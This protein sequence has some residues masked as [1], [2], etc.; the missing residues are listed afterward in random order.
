MIKDIRPALTAFLLA[1]AGI[2]AAVGTRVYPVRLPQGTA[3]ASVV[4]N[5][6]SAIG[7]HTMQGASGLARPRI[8]IDC[9][10]P[11][12]DAATALANL[13]KD[14]LD[15]FRGPMGNGVQ[16]QGAFFDSERDL[17]FDD[18]GKLY[19]VSRDYLVW[20]EER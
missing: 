3:A 16:V 13:V 12:H 14:A 17:P 7:D 19:G 10:A 4:Y 18:D 1:D 8:Q 9:W 2:A 20:Y 15:G 5:R 11:T 6:I